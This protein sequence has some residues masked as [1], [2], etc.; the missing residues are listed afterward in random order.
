MVVEG[1][2][3]ESLLPP[4]ADRYHQTAPSLQTVYLRPGDKPI[5]FS[6]NQLSWQNRNLSNWNDR[7]CHCA[8]RQRLPK[9]NTNRSGLH[10]PKLRVYQA[11]LAG[12]DAGNLRNLRRRLLQ[13]FLPAARHSRAVFAFRLACETH[14]A[15]PASPGRRADLTAHNLNDELLW[16]YPGRFKTY[17]LRRKSWSG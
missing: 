17:T 13:P 6:L 15:M 16:I 12:S 5:S 7:C 1:R 2:L 3:A 10:S 9:A 14:R 8:G 4:C 11:A